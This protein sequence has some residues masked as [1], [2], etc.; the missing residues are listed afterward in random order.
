[1]QINE[2]IEKQITIVDNIISSL[3]G[4]FSLLSETNNSILNQTMYSTIE[5]ILKFIEIIINSFPDLLIGDTIYIKDRK[6]II[7]LYENVLNSWKSFFVFPEEFLKHWGIF[8]TEWNNTK[9]SL[10]R[11][12]KNV[13]T[14]YLS[15]N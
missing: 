4:I 14:I 9:S 5:E 10:I 15:L 11:I 3:N 12:D 7:N 1:M 8:K 13:R 6:I 2:L